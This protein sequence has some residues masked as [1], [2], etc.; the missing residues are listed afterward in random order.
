MVGLDINVKNQ[1]SNYLEKIFQSINLS[2]YDWEVITDDILVRENGKIKEGLFNSHFLNGNNLNEAISKESYYM[3]F[4]DLKAYPLNT[5]RKNIQTYK[6]FVESECRLIFLCTDSTFIEVY[7]K[8]SKTL[9]KIYDNCI[10]Y[11][12]E[13]VMYVSVEQAKTRSM[14]AF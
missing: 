5:K 10:N 4:V 13:S 8:D 6:D 11:S 3:I 2:I 12:F 9:A 1:Y 14:I 7:C